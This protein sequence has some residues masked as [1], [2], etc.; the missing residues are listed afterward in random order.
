[1]IDEQQTVRRLYKKLLRLYP[2]EFRERLEESM[3]QTFADLYNEKRQTKKEKFGFVA[4][5]FV[6]TA[7]GIFREH[8]LLISPGDNMQTKL[9]TLGSS[10]LISLLLILP[11]MTMEVVNRRNLHEEFPFILFFVLWLNLFAISLILLPI[12]R[13]RRTAN[14]G[15]ANLVPAQ[16]N[17]L[18]TNPRS[19]LVIGVVL[20]LFPVILS[21]LDSLGWLS[22]DRL[23]NGPNP[24]GTYFPGQLIS[25]GLI[26]FPVAAGIIARGPIVS[27]VRAGGSLFAHPLHLLVVVVISFLFA[28]GVVGLIV[29]QWPC[30]LG[31]PNCD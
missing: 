8:L 1:M 7:L 23:F 21:L 30:F 4:W 13:G 28:A 18:L 14:H 12:V 24:E 26:L 25:L 15:M 11:F 27:T 10:A 20:F 31:V 16:R 19:A 5:T 29:D 9:Q 2:R 6:E 22:L 17:T 3:E